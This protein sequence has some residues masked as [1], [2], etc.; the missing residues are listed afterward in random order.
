M[1]K[2][3]YLILALL[4]AATP[5]F[6][7]DSKLTDLSE[8]AS[9][10]ADDLLYTVDDPGGTP[11][12][13]KA[14]ISNVLGIHT[15]DTT[16]AH[17]ASAIGF[18]PAGNLAATDV[19]AGLQELD[20]EKLS[21]SG[22]AALASALAANGANCSAGSFPLGVD[23]AGAAESCTDAATQTEL[24]NHLNDTTDAHDA[25]AISVDSTNLT[26]TEITV[27]G[28]LEEIDTQIND[29]IGSTTDDH[30][31]I[32]VKYESSAGAPSA[33]TCDRD[34][35]IQFDT[36]NEKI[37]GCY[38]NGGN[39]IDVGLQ[40]D[41][42]LQ[43]TGDSGSATATGASTLNFDGIAPI[44]TSAADGSPDKI[45]ITTSMAPDR[46]IGRT[47][48]STGVMEELTVGAGLSL[49]SGSLK[50][51][52]KA[53]QVVPFDFTT[54]VAVGDGAFYFRVP[55][56]LNN[57]IL[58]GVSANVVTAGSTNATNVDLARCAATTSGNV[59]SGTVS[60]MLSTNLTID[61]GENDSATAAAPAVIDTANDDVTTGQIIRVDVD[62]VSTTAPK[63]LIVNM[64]FTAP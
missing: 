10:T 62:A 48:A 32:Y 17:A 33:G 38:S 34:G 26:G 22:T 52:I 36:T 46:L 37:Y 27:Q 51:G 11:V 63:G 53:V 31:V 5:V 59:C 7:A 45:T 8:D 40:G 61:S 55:S 28:S 4:L 18:T 56:S 42:Y 35:Q 30:G 44:V 60:D 14:T 23:A 64:E 3:R 39:P 24:D 19:Q 2:L 1:K 15:Q 13:K 12:S 50:A 54:D 25:S 29:H 9:P 43:V 58:T 21:T 47:T 49:G 6:A 41:G 20:S 57:W 16:N